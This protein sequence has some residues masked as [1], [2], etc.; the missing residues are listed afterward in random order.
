M[1]SSRF[2]SNTA[3]VIHKWKILRC[4]LP[5]F[6]TFYGGVGRHLT[7]LLTSEKYSNDTKLLSF[8]SRENGFEKNVV[9]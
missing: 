9:C 3:I 4:F 2:F 1:F 6:N 8:E 5:S 7:A